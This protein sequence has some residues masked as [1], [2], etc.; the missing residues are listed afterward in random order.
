MLAWTV[1]LIGCCKQ[2][3]YWGF[4]Q[5]LLSFFPLRKLLPSF[6]PSFLPQS[7]SHVRSCSCFLRNAPTDGA[8]SLILP[9]LNAA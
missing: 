3:D 9:P 4:T 2:E 6:L 7:A 8:A 1:D 5:N